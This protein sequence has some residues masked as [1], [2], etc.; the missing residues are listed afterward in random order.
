M[1]NVDVGGVD[2]SQCLPYPQYWPPFQPNYWFSLY[3]LKL[4]IGP[5]LSP[6]ADNN[7]FTAATHTPKLGSLQQGH[8][9]TTR[10]PSAIHLTQG[11]HPQ[12]VKTGSVSQR[13]STTT[14]RS[15]RTITPLAAR[16]L[17]LR[18]FRLMRLR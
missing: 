2:F 4:H 11:G 18:S 15:T 3:V 17:M 8:Y 10:M 1:N 5:L 6:P 14:P 12:T 7:L 16:L 9:H 13:P